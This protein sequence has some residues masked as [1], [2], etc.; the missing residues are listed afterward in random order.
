MVRVAQYLP[1]ALYLVAASIVV[2]VIDNTWVGTP[3]RFGRPS[4]RSS[5]WAA[6]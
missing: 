5:P 4:P 1:L 2:N 3:S 6:S